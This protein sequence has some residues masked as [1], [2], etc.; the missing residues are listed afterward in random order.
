MKSVSIRTTKAGRKAPPSQQEQPVAP[1][2]ATQKFHVLPL[3]PCEDPQ[4]RITRRAYE[5]YCERGYRDGSALD[6]WL[7]AEREILS[8]I[9]AV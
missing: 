5:L 2:P 8:Q 1:K 4:A 7:D 6:D 9:P 3:S